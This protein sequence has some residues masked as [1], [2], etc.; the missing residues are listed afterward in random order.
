MFHKI[1]SATVLSI[2]NLFCVSAIFLTLFILLTHKNIENEWDSQYPKAISNF[3]IFIPSLSFYFVFWL[4]L[5]IYVLHIEVKFKIVVVAFTL[6]FPFLLFMLIFIFWNKLFE[7]IDY[8]P[9]NS[10]EDMRKTSAKSF[11][12]LIGF[13]ISVIINSI[14]EISTLQKLSWYDWVNGISGIL[15][16][17]F[18]VLTIIWYM[19]CICQAFIIDDPKYKRIKIFSFILISNSFVWFVL[20]KEKRKNS[21]HKIK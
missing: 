12:M 17:L 3:I 2:I 8:D 15:V 9:H 20:L 7:K 16:I 6:L 21:I 19:L 18:F 13:V 14:F 4:V 1:K 11:A 10:I 5:N